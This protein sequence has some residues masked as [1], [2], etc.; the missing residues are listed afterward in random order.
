[1]PDIGNVLI[2]ILA[3]LV[4]VLIGRT[5]KKHKD[6]NEDDKRPRFPR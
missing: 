6:Q 2:C 1:M 3:L 5:Y 4:G